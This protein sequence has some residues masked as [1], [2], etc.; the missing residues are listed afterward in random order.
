MEVAEQIYSIENEIK[1]LAEKL[2]VEKKLDLTI[3]EQRHS[4]DIKSLNCLAVDDL[5][6]VCSDAKSD[7]VS[8]TSDSRVLIDEK[9]T[10][11]NGFLVIER[12]FLTADEKVP[13]PLALEPLPYVESLQRYR[14][15]NSSRVSLGVSIIGGFVI[16]ATVCCFLL[17]LA[18]LTLD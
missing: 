5:N 13:A 16:T 2:N 17:V 6:A 14:Q 4:S 3:L 9:R 11:F 12:S 8:T 1:Q 7:T 10:Y 18:A 15:K